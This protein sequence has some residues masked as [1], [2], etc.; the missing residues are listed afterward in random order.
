MKVGITLPTTFPW[1]RNERVRQAAEAMEM[2][3]LW[4]SDHFLTFLPPAL[5]REMPLAAVSPDA[6]ARF[7]PFCVCAALGPTT[8]LPLGISV[9]DATRRAAPDLARAAL[10]LQHLCKGGFNLGIGTGEAMNLLPFGYPSDHPVA[11]AEQFLRLLR[12]LLDTGRMPTGVGRIG[13]PLA[14]DK[15]PPRVWMAA[16][17]PR[18]ARLTGRY[19]D[20]WLPTAWIPPESYGRLRSEMAAQAMAAGRPAPESGLN[21]FV[22]LGESRR[23]LREQ[24]EAEP[25]G[26][27]WALG[28]LREQFERHGL[29]HPL[30]AR[31]AGM[32]ELVLQEVDPDRLRGLAPAIPFEV[33]EDGLMLGSAEEVA[34]RIRS[35]ADQGCEHVVLFDLTGVLVGGM[36]EIQA[37]RGEL[38]RLRALLAALGNPTTRPSI[39]A[40]RPLVV[41]A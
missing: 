41:A 26:K 1:T 18:T 2:D 15:G 21:A 3:S 13:L 11:R 16:H 4:A 8:D 14:S 27:L 29:D 39:E 33:L 7:D 9:T 20:G 38:A 12:R 35:Y 30:G 40:D 37:R 36:A 28:Y 34:E 10:T 5:W 19:A 25:L 6:D 24:F 22:A 32:S 23:R 17:G 31:G